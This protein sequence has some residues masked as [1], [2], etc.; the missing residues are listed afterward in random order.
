MAEMTSSKL[1]RLK[2]LLR[3]MFQL[4]RG[5]LDFGLYRIMKVKS[6]EIT[7]FLDDDL[8]PQVERAL[9]LTTRSDREELNK[10]LAAARKAAKSAGYDPDTNPSD[11]ILELSERLAESTKDADAEADV[12]NHL[13]N[14]LI[15]ITAKAI[16]FR[17]V[18][19]PAV[20]DL[21]TSFPTTGR[22][23]NSTG[24]TRISTTS[25]RRRTILLTSSRWAGAS[26]AFGSKSLMPTTR[27]TMSKRPPA[28]NVA[29]CL[30]ADITLSS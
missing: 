18:G 19:T 5:D 12:Y 15:A 6:D 26:S 25:R 29:L 16:S 1:D 14:F 20:G 21:P 8:L 23:S 11:D 7:K 17:S 30:P 4:D 13:A 28:S 3:E 2:T 9:Q 22:K 10:Q 24:P 27:R